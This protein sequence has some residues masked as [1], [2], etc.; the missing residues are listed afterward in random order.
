MYKNIY[1]ICIYSKNANLCRGL[2]NTND[3]FQGRRLCVISEKNY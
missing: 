2:M 1:D 3:C